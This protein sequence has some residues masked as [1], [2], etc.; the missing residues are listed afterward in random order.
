MIRRSG[1]PTRAA[2]GPVTVSWLEGTNALTVGSSPSL[3][4]AGG[5]LRQL[6]AKV[7]TGHVAEIEA[8]PDIVL[9]DRIA[10]PAG[11]LAG[12][13]SA[14]EYTQYVAAENHAVWVTASGYG[15][16]SRQADA[17]A[18]D[19]SLLAAGGILGHSRIGEEWAPTVPPGK[20]ALNLAGYVMAIGALHG[21]HRWRESGEP[22][23]VDVS[24][25]GS[26]IA[27]GLTLEM[28]HALAHCPDEGGSARYGAPS[29]FVDCLDGSVYVL[30]LEEHQWKAFRKA[31]SPV[32]DSV[33]SLVEARKQADYVMAR[34]VEWASTRAA[35]EC[36][37]VL[38]AAG[39]PCNAVNTLST[40]AE[41][42]GS[43]G[44]PIEVGGAPLPAQLTEVPG[45]DEANQ[46]GYPIRLA[47]LRVCE[48]GHVLAVPLAGAW[49]GAMGANVT[50]L[51]DPSRLDVYRRRGPFAEG[52]PGLNRS[53]YFNQLNFCKTRLDVPAEDEGLLDVTAFDV[54]L[55]NLTPRRAKVVGV[56]ADRVLDGDSPALAISSSGFGS[57]GDWSHYRAYGHN[58]HAF[59]GLVAATRD[60]RGEM[61][62]MG[63]PWVDPLTSVAIVAWV[64]AWALAPEHDT[65][66][67]LDISMAE[68]CAAQLRELAG[69]DAADPYEAPEFGGDFFLRL[70]DSRQLVAV[71]LSSAADVS[72]FEEIVGRPL[73][74]LARNYELVQLS[75][76]RDDLPERLIAA[77][78]AVSPVF[79]AS[80]LLHDDFIRSTGLFS[81]V[82][83]AELG[84]YEVTG[85]PWQFVGEDR[86][87]LSAAPE[88]AG[89]ESR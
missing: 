28:A 29:G 37:V 21:L 89:A 69:S 56:D 22:V 36:E 42:A 58:I 61:A 85:L 27:T 63:T 54:V 51:E 6:G 65:S 87:A 14:S 76:L 16:T 40:F 49:L 52:K 78:L 70:A 88:L 5:V 55:N 71:T 67:A 48:A 24:A 38:Q 72:R 74:Q 25:Q 19:L 45:K 44:R 9:V 26:V 31:V 15:L 20:L 39:V 12:G 33:Q 47:D 32:L 66:V 59:A 17:V 4:V 82:E 64:L 34:L 10:G 3:E 43:A 23:H 79:T 80:D 7:E 84:R 8:G 1:T 11:G 30:V 86:V 77:G 73:P 46:A 13:P 57:T 62:D 75:S 81:P 41:R 50:K 18:S 2:T 83:S 35:E 60:A 53:A 68:L